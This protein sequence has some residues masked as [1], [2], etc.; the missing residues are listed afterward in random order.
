MALLNANQGEGPSQALWDVAAALPPGAPVIVMIHGY[1]FSPGSPE[2]DPH[3]HILSLNPPPQA[4]RTTSWPRALGFTDADDPAQGLALGWGWEARGRLRASYARAA[5]AGAELA[6]ILDGLAVTAGRPVALIGHSLG[7]RVALAALE[8]ATPGAVGRLILLAGAELRPRAEAAIASPAGLLA[9]VINVTTRE[10]DVYDFGME[11][12]MSCGRRRALGFGLE[13]ARANWLD[14]QIDSPAVMEAL[15]GLGYPVAGPVSRF[16]H[17]SPYMRPGLFDF[18]AEALR[19]PEALPLPMLRGLLPASGS[20]RWSRLLAPRL[21]RT[22]A[23][24]FGM[25]RDAA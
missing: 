22:D 24:G 13:R 2:H 5:D 1:R 25:G 12:V 16:C 7:A 4:R 9:E 3:A 15:R 10:N 8:R 20:H 19:A 14:L 6:G 21:P 11:L 17:W 23:A 18:Y